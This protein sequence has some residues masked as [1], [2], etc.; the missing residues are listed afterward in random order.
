[1][2][3]CGRPSY[4]RGLCQ[5]HHRQKLTTGTLRPIRPYRKRIPGTVKLAGLRLS[6][7]CAGLVRAHADGTGLSLGAAIAEIL[8]AWHDSTRKKRASDGDG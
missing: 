5:T 7:H 6:R 4:A 2:P 1:M 3:D 8:E